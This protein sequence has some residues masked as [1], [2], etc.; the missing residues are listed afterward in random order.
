METS[1]YSHFLLQFLEIPFFEMRIRDIFGWRPACLHAWSR[2]APDEII[3]LQ[4]SRV[5][6]KENYK[7]EANEDLTFQQKAF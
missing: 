5:T 7:G 2:A 1:T 3:L 4:A 6:R